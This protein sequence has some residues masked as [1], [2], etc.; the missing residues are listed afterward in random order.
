MLSTEELTYAEFSSANLCVVGNLNRDVKLAPV[1]AG[2]YLLEDGETPVEWTTESVG[3]GGANSACAAAALGA[4]VGFLG[5]VGADPLGQ[6]L[7]E[8][9]VRHGVA[10]YLNRSAECMTGTSVNLAFTDGHRHFLSSLPNNEALSISDL[11]LSVLDLYEHMHR[12]DIWFSVSMLQGGNEL[13]FREARKRGLRTSLDINW[14]PQWGSTSNLDVIRQRKMAIRRLLPWVN[15]V[16]G[17]TRELIEFT[18]AADLEGSLRHLKDWGAEAVVIHLGV[19][20]A[21]YWEGGPLVVVPSVPVS[22]QVNTTGTGDVLSVCMMLLDRNNDIPVNKK[23]LL[24]N[25]V[26]AEFIEGKRKLIPS[27]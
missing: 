10:A 17:N 12:A 15:L 21:G 20:G 5:K 16:H 13:L 14:D 4:R 3:G 27:L 26:V 9:L 7:Q 2:T 23:L 6:R 1:K 19:D 8:V 22:R 24:S 11:D 25:Q 18:G